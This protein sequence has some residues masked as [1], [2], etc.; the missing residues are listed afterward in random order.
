MLLV[1]CQE[2]IQSVKIMWCVGVVICLEWSANDCWCHCYYFCFI[3][4]QNWPFWYQFSKIVLLN[5]CL[6][7]NIMKL[8]LVCLYNNNNTRLLALCPRVPRWAG[9]RKVKPVWIYW[10]KNQWVAVASSGPYASLNIAP[11]RQ[12]CQPP[13]TKLFTGQMPLLH[14]TNSTRAL[15]ALFVIDQ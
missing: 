6:S 7:A 1:R 12:P 11:D 3:K 10:R 14:P 9:T 13:T 8:K 5:G 15:K 2:S 4:I